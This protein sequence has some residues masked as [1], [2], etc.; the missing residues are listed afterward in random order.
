M[1]AARVNFEADL[2]KAKTGEAIAADYL[3]SAG[4]QINDISNDA[5]YFHTGIDFFIKKDD[6]IFSLDI[7][8]DSLISKTGNFCLE[9]INYTTGQKGWLKYSQADFIWVVAKDTQDIFIFCLK[10]MREFVKNNTCRKA[11]VKDKTTLGWNEWETIL[12]NI[13]EYSSAYPVQVIQTKKTN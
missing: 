8:F 3:T 12:V 1:N 10:D 5:R 7:K 11:I 6:D 13:N 2:F 9:N 4:W